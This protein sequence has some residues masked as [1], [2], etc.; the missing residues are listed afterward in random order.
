MFGLQRSLSYGAS[1]HPKTN[2]A[3][4]QPDTNNNN[5]NPTNLVPV[6]AESSPTTSASPSSSSSDDGGQTS[7]TATA[8][9]TS[10]LPVAP[11]V[12]RMVWPKYTIASEQARAH[13]M[14]VLDHVVSR[15]DRIFSFGSE[16]KEWMAVQLEVNKLEGFQMAKSE[17]LKLRFRMFEDSVETELGPNLDGN[18]GTGQ[19]NAPKLSSFQEKMIECI[20]QRR[21]EADRRAGAKTEVQQ[22]VKET[23]DALMRISDRMNAAAAASAPSAPTPGRALGEFED[24]TDGSARKK[25]RAGT[26]YEADFAATSKNLTDT[27]TDIGNM[28]AKHKADDLQFRRDQHKETM[29]L[30]KKKEDVDAERWAAEKQIAEQKLEQTRIQLE[31]ERANADAAKAEAALRKLKAEREL[32]I[33]LREQEREQRIAACPPMS[34]E[35]RQVFQ[36]HFPDEQSFR[37]FWE[38][39]ARDAAARDA[40]SREG[41]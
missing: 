26:S 6:T 11:T 24:D 35:D 7:P 5:V 40:A 37:R 17:N 10:K 18:S 1:L 12:N 30:Q 14:P 21:F 34:E 19:N 13:F 25:G 22:P 29:E 2:A 15:K 33:A 28:S 41:N 4:V 16:A 3:V 36:R 38:A 32:R 31:I 27:I 9:S 39:S 20:Q 23:T 8:T